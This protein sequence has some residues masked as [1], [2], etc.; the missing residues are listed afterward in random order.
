MEAQMNKWFAT[1][2]FENIA[3]DLLNS[4][5][6]ANT[7]CKTVNELNDFLTKAK[8]EL[9]VLF[10][11]ERNKQ[12]YLEIVNSPKVLMHDL[13]ELLINAKK[14]GLSKRIQEI[15]EYAKV[16]QSLK[17]DR[18]S[19]E[20]EDNSSL[21]TSTKDL[22]SVTYD[23]SDARE[24]FALKVYVS[25]KMFNEIERFI[26]SDDVLHDAY[27]KIGQL[28]PAEKCVA[29]LKNI[30]LKKHFKY[31]DETERLRETA[32]KHVAEQN[33]DEL[34]PVYSAV[35]D[36]LDNIDEFSNLFKHFFQCAALNEYLRNE[37][38]NVDRTSLIKFCVSDRTLREI[39]NTCIN[40]GTTESYIGFSATEDF[41]K[42]LEYACE[43]LQNPINIKQ[44]T[45]RAEIDS[46][47]NESIKEIIRKFSEVANDFDDV[48]TKNVKVQNTKRI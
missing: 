5:A 10:F 36:P 42:F 26:L 24:A 14:A 45:E 13:E 30:T 37:S 25:R 17:L 31:S 32:N 35:R 4:M 7:E 47:L 29:Q 34:S 23:L 9:F 6:Q 2:T 48:L 44:L 3:M 28:V 18:D 21:K 11:D 46:Q 20:K 16:Y 22:E 40:N 8:A 43:M 41:K 38:M 1:D 39:V 15:D 12:N 33:Q 27:T 19:I